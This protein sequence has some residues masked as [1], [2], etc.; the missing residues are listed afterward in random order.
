MKKMF[1]F[2]LGH[3]VSSRG[4]SALPDML[5]TFIWKDSERERKHMRSTKTLFFSLTRLGRNIAAHHVLIIGN[6]L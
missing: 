1:F 4:Y 5:V 3:T 2:V 6:H